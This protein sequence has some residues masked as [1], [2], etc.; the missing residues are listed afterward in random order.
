MKY[1]RSSPIRRRQA[2][3]THDFNYD[4]IDREALELRRHQQLLEDERDELRRREK[5]IEP[6]GDFVLPSKADLAGHRLWFFKLPHRQAEALRES[7]LT[8]EAVGS[9]ARF[10]YVV[11]IDT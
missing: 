10:E 7:D 4:K 6:W 9:D 3:E 1:L 2:R 8:W 11:V 5:A